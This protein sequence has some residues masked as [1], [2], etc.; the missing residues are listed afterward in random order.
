MIGPSM[1]KDS[2]KI[3]T[4]YGN[5]WSAFC[6]TNGAIAKFEPPQFSPKYEYF[7][8]KK[9]LKIKDNTRLQII[10][11]PMSKRTCTRKAQSSDAKKK[12]D[13]H[14]EIKHLIKVKNKEHSNIFT[15]SSITVTYLEHL[16]DIQ[17]NNNAQ[18]E[19][20]IFGS[21]RYDFSEDQQG[22][23]I[24]HAH[25]GD[26]PL[27]QDI[28][29][30]NYRNNISQI[31]NLRVPTPP[32]DLKAV[33]IGL[34]ADHYSSNL[35]DLTTSSLWKNAEKGLPILSTNFLMDKIV[36]TE[37]IDSLQWYI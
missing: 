15:S 36:D 8:E 32:M 16:R 9:I 37:R 34:V 20:K 21:I 13:I 25:I 35:K 2:K 22:H 26:N 27:D 12:Y 31:K 14:I 10:G 28:A 11:W 1:K 17:E 3:S 29:K 4:A 7:N 19:C 6:K 24:F 33:L 30:R 5:L 18:Q 23:P